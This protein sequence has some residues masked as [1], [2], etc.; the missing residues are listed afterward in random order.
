[1]SKTTSE[2]IGVRLDIEVRKGATFKRQ[3][4]AQY[5]DSGNTLQD[6]SWDNYSGATMQIRRNPK[7]PIA[8]LSLSTDNGSIE[9]LSN[10]R[11]K[12][13]VDYSTMDKIRAGEYVYDMYL[14]GV[15]SARR[16]RDFLFGT[17]TVYDKITI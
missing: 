3:Y 16:K 17:L 4:H 6:F 7:S 5:Y 8:E 11:F 2:R 13:N 9:L 1:M 10:G 14:L 12:L 15:N